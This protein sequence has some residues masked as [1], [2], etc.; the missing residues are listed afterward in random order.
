VR[1]TLPT[2]V[3]P[4]VAAVSSEAASTPPSS[5]RAAAATTHDTGDSTDPPSL[6]PDGCSDFEDATTGATRTDSE[7]GAASGG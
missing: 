2:T 1:V 3:T 6:S 7:T 4:A 5:R